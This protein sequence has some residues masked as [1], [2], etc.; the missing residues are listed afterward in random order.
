MTRTVVAAV[1]WSAVSKRAMGLGAEIARALGARF[2]LVHVRVATGVPTSS[3]PRVDA[4]AG[5]TSIDTMASAWAAETRASGVADVQTVLL[6]G[7]PV[8]SLLGYLEANPADLLVFG[9]RGHSSGDRM[10]LG[11]IS[12]SLLQH[13]RCPVLVVP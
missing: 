3:D 1:D 13:A 6:S 8:D 4:P 12:S 2:I 7:P 10:L 11:G 9:R 5:T